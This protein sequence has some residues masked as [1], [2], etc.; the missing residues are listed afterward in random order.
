M[1]LIKPEDFLSKLCLNSFAGYAQTQIKK[2]KGLNKKINQSIRNSRKSV[3]DFCYVIYKGRSIPLTIWL[4]E[5]NLKQ[6]DC[7]LVSVDH[8]RNVYLL[9]HIRQVSNNVQFKGVVSGSDANDV[10]LS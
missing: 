9:F 7:G 8:F 1:D 2:A 5:N 3:L 6:Q 4:Q 10:I